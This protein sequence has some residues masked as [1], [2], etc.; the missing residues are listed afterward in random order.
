MEINFTKT[1]LG[2]LPFADKT[3]PIVVYH[4]TN[5]NSAGLQL[6]VTATAKAFFIQKRVGSRPERVT[7]GGYPEMT[8]EQA[9]KLAAELKARM[10][11]GESVS[12]AK[13]T[14]R[15][16]MTLQDLFDAYMERKGNFIKRPD[17]PRDAFRLYLS[18]W[19]KRKLSSI[20]HEEVGRLHA[21]IGR[22]KGKVTANNALKLLHVMFNKAL[23]EWRIIKGDNPV[24]GI[25]KF[26]ERSRNRFLQT[27]ELPR[28]FEALGQEENTTIRDYIL[29]SLLT[30]V[31][32]TNVLEM[33]WLQ[34][35]FE[36]MEWR[37]PDTKNGTPAKR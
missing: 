14:K 8:I 9:R 32:K 18:Q 15:E 29:I 3:K 12:E 31:R 23:T 17:K 2:A 28:F 1:A 22:E 33:Q 25:L 26:P 11:A 27:D 16:E 36:R 5:K 10:L 24:H 21:K 34:I 37:I 20:S 13:R 7:L 30:G 35:S 4:D 19:A 6:R